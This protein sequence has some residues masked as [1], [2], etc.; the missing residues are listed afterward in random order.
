MPEGLKLLQIGSSQLPPPFRGLHSPRV[1]KHCQIIFACYFRKS[2][3][4]KTIYSGPTTADKRITQLSPLNVT[5][6]AWS[7]GCYWVWECRMLL[8]PL[9]LIIPCFWMCKDSKELIVVHNREGRG[10]RTV[11][12]SGE[13][14]T[15]TMSSL[16]VTSADWPSL[17]MWGCLA[18][19]SIFRDWQWARDTLTE[20]RTWP[21]ITSN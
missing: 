17:D 6:K 19:T 4:T 21:R 7:R 13:W 3:I 5:R 20:S 9:L 15:L 12:N 16:V 8:T 10:R 1:R 14:C 18:T 2:S 11:R